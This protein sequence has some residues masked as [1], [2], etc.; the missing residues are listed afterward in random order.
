MYLL[1]SSRIEPLFALL[2]ALQKVRV[3][4]GRL[5]DQVHG[6]PEQRLQSFHQAKV[7]IGVRAR[8]E[9]LK[10]DQKVEVAL[11]RIEVFPQGRAENSEALYMVKAAKIDEFFVFLLDLLVH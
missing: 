1:T 3:F 11:L 10:F 5:D 7:S 8:G 2:N 9:R 4:D 6:A